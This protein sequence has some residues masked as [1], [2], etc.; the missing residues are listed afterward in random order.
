V[1]PEI[2]L[3]SAGGDRGDGLDFRPDHSLG[4]GGPTSSLVG[5]QG[6]TMSRARLDKEVRV[7]WSLS[8]GLA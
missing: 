1:K 3:G 6:E 2:R 5:P 8:C 7:P 4:G